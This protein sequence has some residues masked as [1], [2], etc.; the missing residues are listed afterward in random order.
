MVCF[1]NRFGLS[2][3]EPLQKHFGRLTEQHLTDGF[4]IRVAR[5]DLL[6]D[7]VDVA[8]A[9]LEGTAREDRVDAVGL[10]D[11]AVR[12]YPA[13]MTATAGEIPTP[14][15]PVAAGHRFRNDYI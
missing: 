5:L 4:V 7:G 14:G 10:D 12:P 9:A 11:G 3:G 2:P 13:R 1:V 8:E 6:G 15:D